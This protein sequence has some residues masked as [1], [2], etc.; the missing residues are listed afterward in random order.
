MNLLKEILDRFTKDGDLVLDC[1]AGTATCALA[2]LEMQRKFTGCEKDA[3][4]YELAVKRLFKEYKVMY[5]RS[6]FILLI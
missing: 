1:F 5:D 4:C 6:K 3:V 2:C